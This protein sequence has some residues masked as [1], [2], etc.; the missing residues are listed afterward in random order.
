MSP[1][2]WPAYYT[3]T[4]TTEARF[5][6]APTLLG[7]STQDD[8]DIVL[9]WR[10][11]ERMLRDLTAFIHLI[12]EEG[13]RVGQVDKLPASGSYITPTWHVGERVIDVY[14]PEITD[15]CAGGSTV[16]AQVGWYQWLADGLRMT[17]SD[18]PGDT[19]LAGTLTLPHYSYPAE[20]FAMSATGRRRTWDWRKL[21]GVTLLGHTLAG[22]TL[23][24]GA[25][26]R[27]DLLWQGPP[28]Q[29]NAP[30]TVAL[31]GTDASYVLWDAVLAEDAR[32]GDGEALCTRL[33]LRVPVELAPGDYALT[34]TANG[35]DTVLADITVDE[36]TRR[37]DLPP[38]DQPV[39]ATLGDA[40]A[41][42]GY[43]A[44]P[45][46][47]LPD[48]GAQLAVELVWQAVGTPAANYKVFVHLLDDAGQLVAQSDAEPAN[49]TADWLPG[50]VVIDTHLLAL[51][52]DVA[53]GGAGQYRL[54]AGM[55][56]PV[57]GVRL[58]A[59]AQDG[60]PS[61]DDAVALGMW[62]AE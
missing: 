46:E 16:R 23:Q 28:S 43:S 29:A 50:E 58:P 3:P 48:D 44:T 40:I 14:A 32:W 26:L 35:V 42:A 51:P 2:E 25:P 62:V 4:T 17:R 5:N 56:D 41:L 10:G 8:G 60:T 24:P 38:L 33:R 54:L 15:L 36:S 12:D 55:Y 39:N 52:A 30:V 9:Y 34:V 53:A 45:L 59:I 27:L 22:R 57:S 61:A 18:A 13:S 7:M 49:P 31:V 20:R 21:G 11:E 37:F 47:S 19:A 1:R 6:E